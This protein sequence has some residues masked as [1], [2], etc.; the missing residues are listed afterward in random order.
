MTISDDGLRTDLGLPAAKHHGRLVTCRL[1]ELH[2]HPAYAR[3]RFTVP[4][5][6][7][8]SLAAQG[9]RAFQEPIFITQ[10]HLILDGYARLE[11]A[12]QQGRIELPCIQFE[13]SQ[14]EA[15]LWLL[16]K[17]RRSNGLNAFSRILLALDLEP[18]L[19]ERARANQQ[20]GG[21]NKGSSKLTEVERLD[22]RCEIAA[23]A[24]VSVGNVS[25]VKRLKTSATTELL[26]ALRHGE[27]SIHRAWTWS[28]RGSAGQREALWC[29]RSERGVTR[30]I[31]ALIS[32]HRAKTSIE[33]LDLVPLLKA[34]SAL[35][36]DELRTVNVKP[37]RAHGRTIFITEELIRILASQR[38]VL[39]LP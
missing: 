17:H 20:A 2:P 23:A 11:F 27:I 10:D 36:P 3:H 29:Y 22:V 32:K 26:D 14:D 24:G 16:H 18:W 31:R 38:G 19:K 21:Q 35:D 4:A 13:L 25:K 5:H 7:L 15:L 34:L 30:E 9:E 12:R 6:K 37:L 33:S 1:D 28:Q 39:A 8:S